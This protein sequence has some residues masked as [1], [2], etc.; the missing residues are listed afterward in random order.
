[1]A[2]DGPSGSGKSTAAEAVQA[3]VPGAVVIHLDDLLDG[4]TGVES[5]VDAVATQVLSRLGERRVLQ[6][7]RYD[8]HRGHF[9]TPAVVPVAD[10]VLVEG[11]GAGARRLQRHVDLMVWVDADATTRRDR[12]LAR[13]GDD[14]APWFETW[15][16]QERAHHEREQTRR[17]ADLTF[18]T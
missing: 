1:M 10:V 12:A 2:I 18:W 17:R 3:L 4:W 8:W 7:R 16:T 9:T 15:A 11:V 14:Y 6:H 5:A 13:D